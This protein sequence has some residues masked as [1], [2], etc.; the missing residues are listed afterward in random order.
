[1]I[2]AQIAEAYEVLVGGDGSAP[3]VLTCEHASNRMPEPYS[4]P[5]ADQWLRDTHWAWDPGAADITRLLAAELGAVAVLARFTRLLVDPNRIRS[6]GTLFRERA[7]GR[8][9]ELNT[10][11][12]EGERQRR[13]EGW[14]RAY[15]LAIER[16]LDVAPGRSVLSIHSYTPEYE[17]EARAVEVGVLFE[18][19]EAPAKLMWQVYADAGLDARLNEPWSGLDGMMYS[20]TEH[21][22]L[23]ERVALELEFRNDLATDPVQQQRFVDLTVRAL[24]AARVL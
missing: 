3:I 16:V 13:I 14:W 18:V 9:I 20:A 8:L 4:W 11:L 7:E 21:A 2:E 24:K 23:H 15:H 19:D 17:G 22:R 10:G 12:S 1:M 5:W 6:S